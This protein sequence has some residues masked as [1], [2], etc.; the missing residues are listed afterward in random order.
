MDNFALL[1]QLESQEDELMSDLK[2]R[3]RPGESEEKARKAIERRIKT[4]IDKIR[5]KHH[6]LADH[7]GASIKPGKTCIY[8]PEP[9]ISWE[10]K[11]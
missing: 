9:P 7:L 3:V 2:K 1:E 8:I 4:A 6:R 5:K 10:I 11:F